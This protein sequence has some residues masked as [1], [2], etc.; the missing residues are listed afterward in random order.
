MAVLAPARAW[1]R[2]EPLGPPDAGRFRFF[3]TADELIATGNSPALLVLWSGEDISE[4]IARAETLAG[5]H[6]PLPTVI[7]CTEVLPWE[8]RAALA[9][10][11]RGLV[12]EQELDQALLPCLEA[13]RAG[14]VCLPVSEA[15][16]ADPP[17]L[18]NRERQIL[19]LVVMG[20]TNGQIANQLFLAESTI[21]SHL[22]SAF[23]KLGVRSRNEAVEL[24]LE[25]ERNL[26]M[27][28]LGLG[29]EAIE[30]E[31]KGSA[32]GGL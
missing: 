18:S 16:Q 28:I 31:A 2:F 23:A 21:K 17:P 20:Q 9:I 13:V 3:E 25:R 30:F 1:S 27:G 5:A 22:S 15:R 19:G 24:I 4:G 12:L 32:A 7:V 10:G 11:V 29:G 8:L 14:L 6:G 26:G